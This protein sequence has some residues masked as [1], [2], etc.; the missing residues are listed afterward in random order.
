MNFSMLWRHRGLMLFWLLGLIVSTGVAWSYGTVK[1]LSLVEWTDVLGEGCVAL[2]TIL[3]VFS[4]LASRP[5]GQVTRMLVIGLTCFMCSAMLDVFDE[6]LSY[7]DTE[8]W[9]SMVESMPAAVGM[10]IMSVALYLWHLEQL[11]L[12]RQLQRRELVHR[13]HDKIDVITQ[14][15]RADYWRD[16]VCEIQQSGQSCA[17]VILDIN[18]FS[19]FNRQFGDTEGDRYLREIAQLILMNLRA[20]DLAC[21]YAGDRFVVLLPNTDIHQANELAGQLVTSI[22][23]V[24]FK[25]GENAATVFHSIRTAC[26][27]LLAQ[28][29]LTQVMS[30]LNQQLDEE[31]RCAA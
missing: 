5:P 16:R 17:I 19:N 22:A 21:R 11:A 24:A 3:W 28:D 9:I 15:Y 18:N 10:V 27:A 1:A 29:D 2:L 6:F 31:A 14:L 26:H 7:P 30:A 25:S 8:G 12:N 4:A 23:H 20:N 13:N